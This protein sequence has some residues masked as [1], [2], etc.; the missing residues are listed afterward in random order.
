[1]N[2]F[3]NE[4]EKRFKELH[5]PYQEKGRTIGCLIVTQPSYGG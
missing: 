5:T 3:P 4:I 1:M 2:S